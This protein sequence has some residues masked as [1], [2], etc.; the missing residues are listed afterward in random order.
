MIWFA[1]FVANDASDLLRPGM[2]GGKVRMDHFESDSSVVV[3]SSELL[4][5]CRRQMM[6]I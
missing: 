2:R 6:E 3:L 4:F 5:K 1:D